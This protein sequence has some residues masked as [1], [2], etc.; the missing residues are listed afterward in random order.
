MSLRFPKPA[1]LGRAG[2]FDRVKRE[3]TSYPGRYFVLAVLRRA[4]EEEPARVGLITS[5][6]VGESVVRHRVRRRLRELFR[7]A[8][9]FLQ[10]GLWLVLIA[11]AAAAPASFQSLQSEWEALGRRA[12]IFVEPVAR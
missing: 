12:G 2:E 1:R 7:V 11:R 5:R 8:R 4:P 3:G 6:R 10:R 9:P